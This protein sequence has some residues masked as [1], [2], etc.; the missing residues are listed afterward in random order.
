MTRDEFAGW[1][2]RYIE[3]WRSGDRA[4]IGDL[5]SADANYSYQGGADRIAGREAIVASWLKEPDP[6]GTFEAR[7]EPLAIDGPIHATL[8]YASLVYALAID[9][10]SGASVAFSSTAQA[11]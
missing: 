5:F 11:A 8:R 4:A 3:A 1:L 2:D 10:A 9:A 6:P 7:Y